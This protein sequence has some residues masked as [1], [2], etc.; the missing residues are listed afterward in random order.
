[1]NNYS[2]A[3]VIFDPTSEGVMNYVG[4]EVYY[5]DS[6]SLCLK[7]AN[8]NDRSHLGILTDV[9]AGDD[10]PFYFGE[11]REFYFG[12]YRENAYGCII[13]KKEKLKE[14][15]PFKSKEEFLNAYRN[16]GVNN[17]PSD[18]YKYIHT[19]GLWLSKSYFGNYQSV[20][21]LGNEGIVLSNDTSLYPW[22]TLLNTFTFL[23][24]SPCGRL[25]EVN[26]E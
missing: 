23:D 8:N 5:A 13:P 11:C 12:E 26:N 22:D 7:Y 6:P 1:M 16:I 4:Y 15:V 25:Q 17:I 14:Y 3:D 9:I 18:L 2:F 19:K 10:N 21:E 20:V 24:G